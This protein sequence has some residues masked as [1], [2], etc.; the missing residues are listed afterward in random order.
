MF[1]F[2]DFGSVLWISAAGLERSN[3]QPEFNDAGSIE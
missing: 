1:K 3:G 2:F